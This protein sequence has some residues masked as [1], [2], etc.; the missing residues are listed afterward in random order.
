MRLR[1]IVQ[2]KD[3]SRSDIEQTDG[4]YPIGLAQPT[5]QREIRKL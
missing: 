3:A 1:L 4:P 2:P 5:Y